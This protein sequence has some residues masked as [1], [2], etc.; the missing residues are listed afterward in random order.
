MRR[1]FGKRLYY[2][3]MDRPNLE[4]LEA[5]C[6]RR[7]SGGRE[8]RLDVE[9]RRISRH[10]KAPDEQAR[11]NARIGTM[12]NARHLVPPAARGCRIDEWPGICVRTGS[13]GVG[14]VDS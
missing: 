8:S 3:Q 1:S 11:M 12:P 7:A 10:C 14:S 4:P 5:G 13:Q 2:Q 6:R 9:R